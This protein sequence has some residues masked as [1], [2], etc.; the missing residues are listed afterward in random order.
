ME[1]VELDCH[2]FEVVFA[3]YGMICVRGVRVN[4]T[5]GKE[6]TQNPPA[7]KTLK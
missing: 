3:V 5:N 6:I 4:Q 7:E 2:A 1:V